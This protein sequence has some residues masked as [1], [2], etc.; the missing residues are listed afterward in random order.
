MA[1]EKDVSTTQAEDKHAMNKV[2]RLGTA[3]IPELIL[4]FS[5]PAIFGM[6]VNGAYA[7]IDSVFL[8]HGVGEIG[9]SAL[10]VAAPTMSILLGFA[11]LIGSGG[12]ALCA[13][14]LGEGKKAEAENILGNTVMLSL[15]V[16]LALAVIVH[17]PFC[18]DFIL[19]VSNATPEVLP[20][21]ETFI[22]VVS[23]GCVFQILGMAL[24]NFIR[25]CGAPNRALS[26]MLVGEIACTIFNAWFVLVLGWGVTGS[27]L[28]TVLGQAVSC[29]AVVWYFVKT[30]NVP[31]RIHKKYLP[32]N[33]K[34][35]RSI[36]I[37]GMPS[38]IVQAGSAACQLAVNYVLV[39]YGSLDPIGAEAALASV[40]VVQRMGNFVI[41]PLVGVSIAIQPILGFNY[42]AH[43]WSRV[44]STLNYG[45]GIAV[46]MGFV[47]WAIVMAFAPEIVGFFGIKE[48]WMID[49]TA[50]V[51]RVDLIILPTIGLHVVGSN[52]FQATGQPVKSIIL[53]LARQVGYL[54]PMYF[55]LPEVIPHLFPVLDALDG[56]YFAPPVADFL[57]AITVIIF[58]TIEMLHLR[59]REHEE[60]ES[61]E[62]K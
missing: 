62:G 56:V 44:R 45:I 33:K 60:A 49:F 38:F 29:F 24:N 5:I 57:A 21:A 30:P 52:Y 34:L 23:V 16:S 40:G 9:L 46:A 28:A 18:M 51:L 27:A 42:G 36:C 7:L 19:A 1:E 6:V 22:K 58:I 55:I 53:S 4:E 12:N 15:L 47:M 3:S 14:R 2:N 48:Q 17:I 37:M 11:V 26:T 61:Q 13:I 50:F 41:L 35:V 54:I 20:Y 59:R 43:L 39:K 25:T 31:L 32:L 8:G 10:T